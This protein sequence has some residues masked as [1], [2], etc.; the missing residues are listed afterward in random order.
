VLDYLAMLLWESREEKTLLDSAHRAVC[1]AALSYVT[2]CQD[3]V[4]TFYVDSPEISQAIPFFLLD[5][6]ATTKQCY[7]AP[8]R[9]TKLS[10]VC[11]SSAAHE[12]PGPVP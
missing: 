11:V 5:G 1:H 8:S 9:H 3:T 7:H 4:D 2:I 10:L 12:T 6:V